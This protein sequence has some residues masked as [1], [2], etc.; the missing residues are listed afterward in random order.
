MKK[1]GLA[2]FTRYHVLLLI[3]LAAVFL[4]ASGFT[5][6]QKVYDQA[7]L[8]TAAQREE[9]QT[10]CLL[11]AEAKA[12]DVILLTV[13]DAGDRSAMEVADDFYDAHAFGYDAPH[14]TGILM[15]IDMDNRM[16]W[17]STAGDAIYYFTDARIERILDRIFAFLPAS[18]YYQA[19]QAFLAEV[20]H[21]MGLPPADGGPHPAA[22]T[23]P[24]WTRWVV[25]G[26][27]AI[28]AGVLT[29]TALVARAGGV[30]TAGNRTYM[31]GVRV[32]ASSDTFL[33]R[34]VSV[35]KVPRNTGG[36]GGGSSVHTSSGGHSHGGG[37]RGF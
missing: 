26:G 29:V 36:G 14:G 18:D 1:R 22:A 35:R 13:D 24:W 8:L 9:L 25:Q 3:L 7:H 34:T 10:A 33:R 21:Y 19:F 23:T 20:E 30:M 28:L 2:I 27:L 11:L 15:L 31:S 32:R 5:A 16:A 37:G 12:V 17:I 6:G 4:T